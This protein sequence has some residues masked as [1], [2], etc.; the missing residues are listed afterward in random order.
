LDLASWTLAPAEVQARV[1]VDLAFGNRCDRGIP[2]DLRALRVTATCGDRG[3]VELSPYDPRREIEPGRLAP[4][5]E[6]R[7]R[8]AFGAP[9]CNVVPTGVCVDLSGI[10]PG[11]K[12]S[13]AGLLDRSGATK[14][15]ATTI[16]FPGEQGGGAP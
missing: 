15:D 12:R 16:C 3:G 1:V 4:H 13:G 10:T 2:V 11:A 9:S 6:G 7:E 8:I 5:G 14:D